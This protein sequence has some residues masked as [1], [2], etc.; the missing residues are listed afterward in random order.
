VQVANI[1][2]LTYA[3]YLAFMHSQPEFLIM[4]LAGFLFYLIW[5]IGSYRH[6]T[7]TQKLGYLTLAPVSVLSFFFHTFMAPLRYMQYIVLLPTRHHDTV[8]AMIEL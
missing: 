1:V 7:F 3:T 5:A 2:T 8:T 6:L 4:Y